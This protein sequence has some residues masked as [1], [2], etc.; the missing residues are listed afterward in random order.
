MDDP[1]TIPSNPQRMFFSLRGSDT[2]T[3]WM[4]TFTPVKAPIAMEVDWVA[5]TPLGAACAFNESVLCQGGK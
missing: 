3:D 4:G 5:F 1:K 2:L